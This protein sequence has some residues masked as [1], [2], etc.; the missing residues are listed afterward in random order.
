VH[1]DGC[2]LRPVVRCIEG[3]NYKLG[4]FIHQVL[5][6]LVGPNHIN[7]K[8]STEFVNFTREVTL[9]ENYILISLDVVSLFTNVPKKLVNKIIDEK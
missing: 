7:V 6:P 5:S 8:D 2:K 1:K 4:R 3:L 9:P